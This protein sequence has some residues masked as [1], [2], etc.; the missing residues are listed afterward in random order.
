MKILMTT[1]FG[2]LAQVAVAGS[3]QNEIKTFALLSNPGDQIYN[4]EQ[5]YA[6]NIVAQPD[7]RIFVSGMPP[8]ML[9]NEAERR[10]DFHPDFIQGGKSWQVIMEAHAD[11]NVETESFTVT[12]NN[13]IQPPWPTVIATEYFSFSMFTKL[14]VSQVTDDFLDRPG[15]AGREFLSTFVVP[16]AGNAGNLLPLRIGL[17][18]FGGSPGTGGGRN[19]FGLSPNDTANTWWTGYNDQLFSGVATD[20]TVPNYTQRRVMHLL[21]YLVEHY[22]GVDLDNVSVSGQSMGGTG[23]HFLALRYARHFNYISSRIGGTA[24]QLL[25]SGQ[26]SML[27]AFWGGGADLGLVDDLGMDVWA[28]YDSSRGLLEDHDFRNLHFTSVVGQ[29]DNTISFRHMVDQSPVTGLSFIV[30]LQQENAG[31][32]IIWD[33]R[34]H[35]GTEGPP[36][37]ANWW[38]RLDTASLLARNQ[39]FPAFSNSSADDDPGIP[40]GSGGF[41]GRLRGA[42]NRYQ[43]WDSVSIVDTREQFS[44]PI[45][46]DIDT[47]GTPP[48]PE[49]PPKGNY[50]YGP[51]PIISDVTVR[52]IQ[53]FQLMAGEAVNWEYNGESGVVFANND[54]SVTVP[55]LAMMTTYTE[56]I[57]IRALTP[58]SP[59]ITIQPISQSI[60]EGASVTFSVAAIGSATLSFQWFRNGEPISEATSSSYT[61]EFVSIADDGAVY[62]CEVS[63]SLGGDVSNDAELTVLLDTIPPTIESAVV[64][65][66]NQVDVVFSEVV[67]PVSAETVANYQISD[68][69]QATGVSLSLDGRTVQLQTDTLETDTLYTVTI[70]NIQDVSAAANEILADSSIEVLFAPVISFDNGLLPFEWAPLT[71]SRWSVVA[72]EGDNALFLNTT[73]YPPLS[74]GRL[75]EYI[76]SPDSYADFTLTVE[77]KTNES[78]GNANADYA[79]VFGFEDE[80][81]YYYML[82]NR[83]QSNTALFRVVGGIREELVVA[84]AGVFNN[85]YNT[86]EVRRVSD[87]IEVRFD[88]NVV[89]MH[90]DTTSPIGQIGVGSF[91]DSAYFDDIFITTGTNTVS[92]LIFANAFE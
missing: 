49:F 71:A 85:D 17:H 28:S 89:L 25:S 74:G 4:E 91:N 31:H 2:M 67:T 35:G 88:G 84:T 92:D 75:G 43:I 90:T 59:S 68:D 37:G 24:A 8:G 5:S 58:I 27:R 16:D 29:N 70:N 57:L 76:L 7:A 46:V 34:A 39:A 64:Q 55:N 41:T 61:V 19:L 44:I 15:Y 23:S 60:E 80:N 12:V 22:P 9:W 79:L 82:F 1:I 78:S 45:K 56:L 87:D 11:G 65:S 30:A 77:A 18:A 69:I 63:N 32:N 66:L 14:T 53:N 13:N 6:I 26:Q 54:G 10:F 33:Q 20:G 51:T 73:D 40:D 50:Y 42:I 36:L 81:N 72:D 86:V 62:H 21:S 47:S 48:D 38:E 3:F 52:R 83:T